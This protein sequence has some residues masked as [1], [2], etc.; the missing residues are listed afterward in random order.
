[1]EIVVVLLIIAFVVGTYYFRTR[2]E[3]S[4]IVKRAQSMQQ[5]AQTRKFYMPD[6]PDLDSTVEY[7][8]LAIADEETGYRMVV[9]R[10]EGIIQQKDQISETE[11]DQMVIQGNWRHMA[12]RYLVIGGKSTRMSQ[13]ERSSSG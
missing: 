7:L 3:R 13:Y 4:E 1:M 9:F 2:L 5:M 11:K 6:D 10:K 12:D 8:N